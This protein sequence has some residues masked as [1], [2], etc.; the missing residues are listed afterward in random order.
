MF[1]MKKIRTD[2]IM[3][4]LGRISYGD[5]IRKAKEDGFDNIPEWN[6]W[7]KE[8]GYTRKRKSEFN[9]RSDYEDYIAKRKG[10]KDRK[11]M[12]ND[13]YIKNNDNIK[14]LQ[15]IRYGSPAE[16]NSNCSNY[17][18]IELGE[19]IIGR[20]AIPIL[21]GE[22][23][24][25]MP[26]KNH[27]FDFIATGNIK[28]DVKVRCLQFHKGGWIGWNYA[29]L[30]NNIADIFLLIG[31]DNREYLNP[32]HVW[33]FHKN[34]IIRKEKFWKRIGFSITDKS[35]FQ[36]EFKDFEVTKKLIKLKDICR[37][38]I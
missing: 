26:N 5:L 4:R 29:I 20:Y 31:L 16:F 36:K 1:Y 14:Y 34:D 28:I 18:G 37:D 9:K 7:K 38:I 30:Y 27:G 12:Y 24:E 3:D 19:K 6:K 17:L 25:E 32:L 22:I 2:F 33:M 35:E 10:Y 15:Q 21:I 23:K 13:N 11:E 8:T